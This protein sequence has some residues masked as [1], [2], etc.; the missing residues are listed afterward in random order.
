MAPAP[1]SNFPSGKEEGTQLEKGKE[2]REKQRVI[3]DGTYFKNYPWA[4]DSYILNITQM[5]KGKAA[6][7]TGCSV[8][9]SGDSTKVPHENEGGILRQRWENSNGDPGTLHGMGK[10][11]RSGTGADVSDGE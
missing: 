3:R 10:K 9:L 2:P 6:T 7:L 11:V 1:S 5:V 4:L 8:S